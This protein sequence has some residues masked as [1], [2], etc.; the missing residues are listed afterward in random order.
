MKQSEFIRP[1]PKFKPGGTC[2]LE[3]FKKRKSVSTGILFPERQKKPDDY[4]FLLADCFANAAC[5]FFSFALLA[6]DC[7]C[8][9]FFWF[10]FGD[11]SPII[12]L[13]S[14]R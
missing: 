1:A 4:F 3:R 14:S 5:F 10:D 13:S 7:F 6:L 12:M 2:P 9:D 11:L 8:V